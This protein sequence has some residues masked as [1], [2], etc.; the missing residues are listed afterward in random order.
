[1]VKKGDETNWEL[2][3]HTMISGTEVDQ[4]LHNQTI[5]LG[6]GSHQAACEWK[7]GGDP[8][9]GLGAEVK[10]SRRGPGSWQMY[11]YRHARERYSVKAEL[12][13]RAD[14]HYLW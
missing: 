5:S 1:M 6:V 3:A 2:A 8:C 13:C 12:I 7:A 4:E 9:M 14:K 10:D 11:R